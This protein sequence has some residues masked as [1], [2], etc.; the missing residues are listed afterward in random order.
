MRVLKLGLVVASL[1]AA[2]PSGA[3]AADLCGPGFTTLV[4]PSRVSCV[5]SSSDLYDGRL[6]AAAAVSGRKPTTSP[7]VCYGDGQTGP[8]VQLVYGYVAG[9]R[10]RAATAVPLISKTI[11]P[12]MQAVVK[13]AS[14]GKD[15]GIRFAFNTG[16]QGLSVPV[17]A[18]P[19]SV[20]KSAVADDQLTAMIDH[21]QSLGY[22][23]TDRKYQ[24]VWDWWNNAG[25]CGL[26]ELL[27][28]APGAGRVHDGV[29]SVGH[30][31]VT[32]KAGISQTLPIPRYSAVWAHVFTPQGP[33]C[34]QYAQSGAAVEVHEL[35]HTLGAVQL[36]APHSDGGGHCTD[37]PS[38]MCMGDATGG[39]A[40]PAC[41]R[42]AVQVLD[43]GN[44]DYWNPTPVS[45][46]YLDGSPANIAA[47]S[48]FGPQV[49][50][51]LAGAPV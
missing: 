51:R 1:L 11:A 22:D 39:V 10:N 12:R 41:A 13:A 8:R 30:T 49:Q 46:S 40:I 5:H 44:D 33:D 17:V 45:G 25:V 21:L 6:Q 16:C 29:P 50:D 24:V 20:V 43:C 26:G 48:Y 27:A 34:W 38:I 7:P 2:V 9:Q 18:F 23:R 32:Q 28:D 37:S 14:A 3:R 4:G 36:S 15:L 42:A 35:F 19:A 47:S 31:D